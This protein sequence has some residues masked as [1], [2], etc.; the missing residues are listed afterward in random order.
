MPNLGMYGFLYLRPV[1]LTVTSKVVKITKNGMSNSKGI[2]LNDLQ[3][4]RK[5][6]Q[7]FFTRTALFYRKYINM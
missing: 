2:I 3:K 7:I 5:K 1:F 6:I 4:K